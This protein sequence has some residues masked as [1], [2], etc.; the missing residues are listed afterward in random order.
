MD[1]YE[2]IFSRIN[3]AAANFWSFRLVGSTGRES[4]S[5]LATMKVVDDK[6]TQYTSNEGEEIF[7]FDYNSA[8]GL[9]QSI[10]FRPMLSNAQAIRTIY[11]QTN[12][13]EEKQVVL[14]ESN[15]MLDYRFKKDRLS[16]SSDK[17]SNTPD[18]GIFRNNTFPTTM[19]KV[20]SLTPPDKS[21]QIMTKYK[22]GKKICFR[23]AI[24]P[25][26]SQILSLLLDDS[27]QDYNP[28]YIGIMPGIQ[29]EFTLQGISGIRTFGM[30]RVRGLPEPY[31]EE[32]IV[33]RVVN[34]NDN[35]QNGQWVTSIVAGVIPLRGYFRSKLR[36]PTK[37]VSSGE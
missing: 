10:N 9:L 6:L 1:V 24:P 26:Y 16:L 15:E 18:E 33:F 27:D 34:V 19:R 17:T 23:L 11:A 28:R 7:T 14:S 35:I 3:S 30:F 32:N 36:L 12:K 37:P 21:F 8:D 13:T 25:E 5:G 4:T 29:A 2:E 31:S 20:Q 22:D